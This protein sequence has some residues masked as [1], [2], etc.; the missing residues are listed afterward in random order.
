MTG[1]APL[2][3]PRLADAA[4][5]WLLMRPRSDDLEAE[6]KG[7]RHIYAI[8]SNV[9]A[10]VGSPAQYAHSQRGSIDGRYLVGF[11]HVFEE[12]SRELS[13]SIA[14]GLA[15]FLASGALGKH[16]PILLVPPMHLEV[17]GMIHALNGKDPVKRDGEFIAR[18]ADLVARLS[19]GEL[20]AQEVENLTPELQALIFE[21]MGPAAE[22]RRIARFLTT[23]ALQPLETSRF[24]SAISDIIKPL[25]FAAQLARFTYSEKRDGEN[26]WAQR[27]EQQ[28][29]IWRDDLLANDAE[30]LSRI[31]VWNEALADLEIVTSG[32]ENWRVIYITSDHR[33][34]DAA[35][36]YKCDWFEHSFGR[37]FIRHPRA[38]LA[39]DGVL[40]VNS[41][42]SRITARG[43]AEWFRLLIEPGGDDH[44]QIELATLRDEW[45]VGRTVP[46][47]LES[48][49]KR[50]E[51]VTG[52]PAPKIEEEWSDFTRQTVTLNPP[53]KFDLPTLTAEERR[54]ASALEIVRS[55]LQEK[56]EERRL[57]SLSQYMEAVV[58]LSFEAEYRLPQAN[59]ARNV[60]PI[61]FEKW[62]Q[63]EEFIRE[64]RNWGTDKFDKKEYDEGLVR[65]A[66]DD[67]SGYAF[68]LGHAALFAGRGRWRNASIMARRAREISER[69]SDEESKGANGRE[70][71]YL[72][73]FCVRHSA[74]KLSHLAECSAL[75]GKA[76]GI[77]ARERKKSG[78]FDI[79]TPPLDVAAERFE[80]E[81]LALRLTHFFFHRY[82]I[83]CLKEPSEEQEASDIADKYWNMK[84]RLAERIESSG[85]NSSP[86]NRPVKNTL[87]ELE[88]RI[89]T[90]L[91]ALGLLDLQNSKIQQYA[92]LL[93]QKFA[94]KHSMYSL[95]FKP[96]KTDISLFTRV[97][98]NYG[99]ARSLHGTSDGHNLRREL[100]KFRATLPENTL[101]VFPYDKQ[102]F[103][104][105]EHMCD[106]PWLSI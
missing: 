93:T 52:D 89:E 68:Y 3:A 74:K 35:S 98:V 97:I 69:L 86:N 61:F 103:D 101:F 26:G 15:G 55:R 95:K 34:L 6:A 96:G 62:E 79:D 43:L 4:L 76:E 40:D 7:R 10:F 106:R 13:T 25:G 59:R 16:A 72:E 42:D 99:L 92:K 53:V 49:L 19:D 77:F 37:S 87:I 47:A 80:A 64:V 105:I 70:A 67:P 22:A 45:F 57:E 94:Q 29:V 41:T 18:L 91:V 23:G 5:Q 82:A 2:L 58:Q 36:G 102:R 54:G 14:R 65:L 33:I 1:S 11:G 27:L 44:T 104:E 21:D 81:G 46:L 90:N 51:A 12:D 30:V 9:V 88:R 31:E 60:V 73:A 20:S 85:K 50:F 84:L 39:E 75:I 28:S 8:D 71:C 56:L 48:M 100:A 83:A 78:E 17:E 24:P 32:R 66:E 63:A 38:Y